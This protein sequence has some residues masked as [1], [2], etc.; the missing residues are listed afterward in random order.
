VTVLDRRAPLTADQVLAAARAL[1]PTI[2]ERAAEVEAARRMPGDLL[3]ALVAA[4][5]FRMLLPGSHGGAGA[6]V[7][8]ALR[9]YETL[10]E[11][12]AS[13]AWTVMIGGGAWIDLAGLPRA[14]FDG[15]FAGD[16]VIVAGA[17]APSGSITPVDGGYRVSGRWGFASG[18]QHATVLY[19]DCVEGGATEGAGGGPR[20][21]MA[22]FGPDQVEIEDTW[23]VLGLRGTGSHH[24]RVADLRVPA[25]R[26]W[27]PLEDEPCLDEPVVRIPV[28]SLIALMVASVAV[29]L[30]QGA[31]DDAV[32]LAPHKVPLLAGAPLAADPLFQADLATADTE[33][34]AARALLQESA[35]SLWATAVEGEPCTLRQRAQARAAAVWAT[36]RAVAVVET[37]YRSG[38]GTAIYRTCPLERRLRDVHTLTQHFIVRQNT[39]ATAGAVLAG[40]DVQVPVF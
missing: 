35:G 21:R 5:C 28:P 4:G 17:F 6:D 8:S 10:A 24:I 15:V 16:D 29:G 38:G 40:R 39:M 3:D 36:A 33:L 12:D 9:L 34:R 20:L 11:A 31:L 2:S 1:R 22:I 37:A 30:A 32:A 18:C 25:D 23:S 7:P 13:V 26:T 19:G 27:R 14:T